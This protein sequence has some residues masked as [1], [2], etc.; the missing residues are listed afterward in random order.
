MVPIIIPYHLFKAALVYDEYDPASI[1]KQVWPGT[2]SHW[3]FKMPE[4]KA[5][6]EK[7]NLTDRTHL[8]INDNRRMTL[9]FPD[10]ASA[11]LFKLNVL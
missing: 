5:Y 1:T 6:L 10:E 2:P 8:A 3:E 7:H 11:A 9:V 4:I